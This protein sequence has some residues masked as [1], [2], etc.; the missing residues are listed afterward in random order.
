VTSEKTACKRC[1]TAI[2]QITAKLTEG[3]CMPCANA[4]ARAKEPVPDYVRQGNPEPILNHL[5]PDDGII[6]SAD[7]HPGFTPDLTGWTIQVSS[8]GIVRQAVQWYRKNFREEELLK[9]ITLEPL[10]LTE[11]QQLIVDCPPGGF[12][13]LE[14]A[15]CIDDAANVS[16]IIPPKKIRID[17]PY[18]HLAQDLKKG[19]RRFDGVQTSLFSLF[20]RIW[21]F[22]D[23]H[24]PYSLREHQKA[25][26]DL[27]CEKNLLKSSR[28]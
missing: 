17:L 10:K 16:L 27:A 21:S 15:A 9:P 19:L 11:I 6:L 22:A 2:L 14:H 5:H 28:A 25:K 7:Y 13:A 4:M 18:F 20:G 12:Q 26:Q 1:G 8:D 23:R 24:A 3:H